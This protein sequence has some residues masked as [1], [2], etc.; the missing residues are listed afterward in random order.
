[1]I[2]ASRASAVCNQRERCLKVPTVPTDGIQR[3]GRIYVLPV[4]FC[5]HLVGHRLP[6]LDADF[7]NCVVPIAETIPLW[8]VRLCSTSHVRRSGGNRRGARLL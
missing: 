3:L 2:E 1:M 5:V 7:V 6:N 8:Q 4:P